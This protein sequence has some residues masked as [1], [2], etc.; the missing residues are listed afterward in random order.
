MYAALV[1]Q[2]E[3]TN[4]IRYRGVGFNTRCDIIN[5]DIDVTVRT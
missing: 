3:S 1:E 2:I 5:I 4:R